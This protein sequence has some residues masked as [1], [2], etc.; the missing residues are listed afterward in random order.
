MRNKNLTT[1]ERK[2]RIKRFEEKELFFKM[3]LWRN[4][5]NNKTL[6]RKKKMKTNKN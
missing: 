5:N 2:R 3:S 1:K 6:N 4:N